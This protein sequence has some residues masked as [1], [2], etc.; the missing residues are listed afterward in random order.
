M[1][2]N[3]AEFQQMAANLAEFSGV[4]ADGGEFS[5]GRIGKCKQSK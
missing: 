5:G 4:S 3:V 1:A 2:A